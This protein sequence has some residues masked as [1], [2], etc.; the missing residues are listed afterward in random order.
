MRIYECCGAE[1]ALT[2]ALPKFVRAVRD[3]DGL[4]RP[5]ATVR[6]AADHRLT[7]TLRPFEIRNLILEK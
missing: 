6:A 5:L 7:L 1:T 3:A 2:L 4:E